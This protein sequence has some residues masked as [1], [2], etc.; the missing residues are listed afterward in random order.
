MGGTNTAVA[1]GDGIE[2]IQSAELSISVYVIWDG[3]M[4]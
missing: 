2:N 4:W 3:T 1:K